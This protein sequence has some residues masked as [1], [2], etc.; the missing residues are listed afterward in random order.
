MYH[1]HLWWIAPGS[2]VPHSLVGLT[3][4]NSWWTVLAICSL[5]ESWSGIPFLL[6]PSS[7]PGVIFQKMYNSILQMARPSSKTSGDPLYD[8]TIGTC[9]MAS[10]PTTNTSHTTGWARSYGPSV[11]AACTAAKTCSRALSCSATHLKL[12]VLSSW[13]WMWNALIPEMEE[14]APL[15]CIFIHGKICQMW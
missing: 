6:Q 10:L 12:T 3:G 1:F 4:L 15:W 8:S 2:T 7:M 13:I 14:A 11:R 9:H 5:G